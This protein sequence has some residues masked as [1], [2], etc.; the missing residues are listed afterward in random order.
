M[1]RKTTALIDGDILVY[2]IAAAAEEAIRWDE[3][4]WT[5]HSEVGPAIDILEAQLQDIMEATGCTTCRPALSGKGNFR[6]GLYPD[7]KANRVG[8]RKPLCLPSLVE[9]LEEE[10]NGFRKDGLEADDV[11]GIWQT[12]AKPA[13]TILV[14][15]DKDLL[16]IPGLHYNP[17]KPSQGVIEVTPE[18]AQRTHMVQT[19]EGDNVDNIPGCPTYGPKKADRAIPPV[20]TPLVDM[21]EAVIDCFIKQGKTPDDALLNARLTR[22]LHATDYDFE[23]GEVILWEPPQ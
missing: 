18:E 6:Y 9:Y 7:Y 21:W 10:W 5:L 14:S 19:L 1:G 15:A 12:K 8:N 23:V 3:N 2:R 13:S 11:L 22:I 4:L 20:G 17:L 16:T